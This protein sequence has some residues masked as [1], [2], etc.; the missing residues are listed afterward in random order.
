MQLTFPKWNIGDEPISEADW[1]IQ[2]VGEAL[3][4]RT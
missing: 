2:A 1:Y 3:G 4:G